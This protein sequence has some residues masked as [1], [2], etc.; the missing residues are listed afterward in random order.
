M[1]KIEIINRGLVKLG[2]APVSSLNDAAYGK[3]FD[4]VYEDV[5]DL[6]LSAYPWRFAVTV[7]KLAKCEALYNGK[8]MYRLP[9]DCLLLLNVFGPERGALFNHA[10]LPEQTY[11]PVGDCVVSG[12]NG[13][14]QA[15]Y[16]QR[17][18]DVRTFSP[19]FKEA[20]AVKLAAELALRLKHSLSLKQNFDNEFVYLIRQAELNNEIIKDVEKVPENSWVLARLS[21]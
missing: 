5:K 7:K 4:L 12:F 8:N 11:E 19:L 3:T 18:D 6:L 14:L 20:L 1:S 10:V 16:V 21:V 9:A 13:P 2:E 15:E 17:L